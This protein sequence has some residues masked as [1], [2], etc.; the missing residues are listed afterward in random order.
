[1]FESTQMAKELTEKQAHTVR[2]ARAKR[3]DARNMAPHEAA[4]LAP[5]MKPSATPT[6]LLSTAVQ[7]RPVCGN[8]RGC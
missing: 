8:L 5:V 3:R 6:G 4:Q 1:M 2:Q 7:L